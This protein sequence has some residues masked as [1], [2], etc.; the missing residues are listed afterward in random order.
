MLFHP[1]LSRSSWPLIALG[2]SWSADICFNSKLFFGACK[3]YRTTTFGCSGKLQWP[4]SR[5]ATKN[6]H[7]R[8]VLG[9]GEFLGSRTF[10]YTNMLKDCCL[11]VIWRWYWQLD[12]LGLWSF[13]LLGC[14]IVLSLPLSMYWE[15]GPVQCSFHPKIHPNL[16]I[17]ESSRDSQPPPDSHRSGSNGHSPSHLRWGIQGRP[18]WELQAKMLLRKSDHNQS[19]SA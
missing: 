16:G 11:L 19:I 18:E 12:S 6:T 5:E 15:W 17:E 9:N 10:I 8:E 1:T 2:S 4:W 7:Y 3:W 14:N 13:M